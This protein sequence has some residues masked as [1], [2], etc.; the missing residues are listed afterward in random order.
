MNVQAAASLATRLAAA[1]PA[2]AVALAG[3]ALVGSF[4]ALLEAPS[5]QVSPDAK[6]DVLCFFRQAASRAAVRDVVSGCGS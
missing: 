2:A 1:S 6:L 4:A 3:S 5:T